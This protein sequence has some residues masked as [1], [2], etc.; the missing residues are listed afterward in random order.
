MGVE[1]DRVV[2]EREL[3]SSGC[4]FP[5]F[6]WMICLDASIATFVPF[7][8]LIVITTHCFLLDLTTTKRRLQ[9]TYLER[10]AI[11]S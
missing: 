3:T 11:A 8:T 2:F 4:F 6:S 9:D 7:D 5:L 10:K 1:G